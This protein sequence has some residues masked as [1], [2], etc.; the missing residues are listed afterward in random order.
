MKINTN[1]NDKKMKINENQ[2]YYLIFRYRSI[3]TK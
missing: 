2:Y 1:I 3:Y